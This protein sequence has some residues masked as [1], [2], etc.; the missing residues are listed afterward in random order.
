MVDCKGEYTT[1]KDKSGARLPSSSLPA[2]LLPSTAKTLFGRTLKR[3]AGQV[4]RTPVLIF[5]NVR[6]V[7]LPKHWLNDTN[8]YN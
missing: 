7:Y 4:Q 3:A 2:V 8:D 5:R 1:R 6:A